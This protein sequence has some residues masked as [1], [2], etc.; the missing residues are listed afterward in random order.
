MSGQLFS[1]KNLGVIRGGVS[2]LR[3]VNLSVKTGEV[4][5]LIGPNGAGKSTLF[6]TI[7]GLH[8]ITDG[9]IEFSGTT[10]QS[11]KTEEISK[12]ISLAPQ[13]E[14][15]FPF[16]TVMENLWIAKGCSKKRDLERD[17]IFKLFP[18]LYER[19]NQ[20]ACTLSG[21]QRQMLALGISL[22]R[23]TELLLLD[24]PALGLAPIMVTRIL[25]SV[26]EISENYRLS[27]LISEQNPRVLD[28][29][30][31]VYVIEGGQIR[32]EGD[33]QELKTDERV[34]K[35]YLGMAI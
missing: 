27:I 9:S 10:I 24:E 18:V 14:A 1:I 3:N 20:L 25:H 28:I 21:G 26:K 34:T 13:E 17:N 19:K 6:G 4:V 7:M 22:A 30:D 29:A 5:A 2:V 33:A 15:T 8:Q 32:M 11:L 35:I 31:R 12:R 23:K 16:L